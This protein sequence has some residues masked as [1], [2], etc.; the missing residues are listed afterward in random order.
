MTM[1]KQCRLFLAAA[2]AMCSVAQV[3]AQTPKYHFENEKLIQVIKQIEQN[4]EFRFLYREAQLSAVRLSLLASADSLF[5]KLKRKLIPYQLSLDVDS[6]RKQVI[7]YKP[8]RQPPDYQKYALSGYVVDDES[9][10]R[11]PYATIAWDT[12]PLVKGISANQHGYFDIKNM[13]PV[14]D[15]LY[16]RYLG[17]KTQQLWLS[18]E[19]LKNGQELTIRLQPKPFTPDE[20]TVQDAQDDLA[21]DSALEGLIKTGSFSPLGENNSI[22]ALQTLPSVATDAA[23]T[24]GLNVRGSSSNGFRILLDG[25]TLYNQYHLFGLVDAM[26]AEVLRSSGFHYDISP[27]R[28]QAPL[29]GTLSLIT[30]TGSLN[31]F[32]ATAG[33]SNS[34]AS[35]TLE[36][37]VNKGSSSWL[38]SG[39]YSFIDSW[40]F[41]GNEDLIEYGLDVNRPADIT[42]LLPQ[43]NAMNLLKQNS[44]IEQQQVTGTNADFYDIHAK[45]YWEG[46]TGNQ[47]II[48]GYHGSDQ[49]HQEYIRPISEE[50]TASFATDNNWNTSIISASYNMTL[51]SRTIASATVGYSDY[52]ASYFKEDFRYQLRNENNGNRR[53]TVRIFPLGLDNALADFSLKQSLS[54][55]FDDFGLEY[56]FSYQNLIVTYKEQSLPDASFRSR[57]TS[58]LAD[59]FVQLNITASNIVHLYSGSRLHYF[60]NGAYLRW[61]PRLKAQFFNNQRFSFGLGY[62]RNYQF[63]HKLQFY[64]INSSDFWIMSNEDQPPSS[65]DYLSSN[66]KYRF[67]SGWYLQLE[68][69]L[70]WFH[71]LRL[72]QLNSGLLSSTF[73]NRKSPWFY[74]NE[75]FARGVELL[76]RKQIGPLG[77]TGTYT[78]SAIEVQ[79]DRINDG[80]S[81]Y[82]DWDRRH[83]AGLVAEWK[84][85]SQFILYASTTY[86]SGAPDR[87][88]SFNSTERDRMD[89]FLRTDVSLQFNRPIFSGYLEAR[90][91]L[92]N[93]F[94]R[95]NPWYTEI[96]PVHVTQPAM[97]NRPDRERRIAAKTTVYD[98]GFQPSFSINI[99]F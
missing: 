90:L 63:L 6:A 93:V 34:A 48:S 82:P 87:L 59:L 53:D 13:D 80:A 73:T 9:G 58:Q 65:V 21:A 3:Q 42:S 88:N 57:R 75:G 39:R 81:F 68:S 69:Y 92:F 35:A 70:K 31:Q 44:R 7:I 19:K 45:T 83:Q 64:N 62:S 98:L 32:N 1:T 76:L 99:R 36:G 54:T 84:V 29:G 33:L 2:L 79:N 72:H 41:P 16:V 49:T 96:S 10:E 8:H 38:L 47:L 17:Y 4:T 94:N 74:N 51:Q 61:S 95:N 22:R 66:L 12:G 85:N 55:T 25:L 20:I 78:L 52:D 23:V 50:E 5:L 67:E 11:L 86:A 40:N 15:Q 37:P 71:N 18:E 77:F 26:N 60:S 30:K 91:S 27:A 89:Y 46:V 43:N 24:N 14:S 56:G 28:Y 97:G